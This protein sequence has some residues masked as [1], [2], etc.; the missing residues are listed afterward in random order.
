M[1]K[2]INNPF[3]QE[4]LSKKRDMVDVV[5]EAIERSKRQKE[6]IEDTIKILDN[7]DTNQTVDDLRTLISEARERLVNY[8][9]RA[10]N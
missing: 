1:K 10:I 4:D 7:R 5:N 2:S 8:N 9:N 6:Y 3:E